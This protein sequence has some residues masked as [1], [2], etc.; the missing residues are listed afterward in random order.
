MS[1]GNNPYS[2]R[3]NTP[4]NNETLRKFSLDVSAALSR[5]SAASNESGVIQ[6][7]SLQGKTGSWS[8]ALYDDVT[9]AIAFLPGVRFIPV[10]GD[11]VNIGFELD[12]SP[13]VG[14]EGVSGTSQGYMAN[15]GI[16]GGS[17]LAAGMSAN[18]ENVNIPRL[19]LGF[20]PTRGATM[21]FYGNDGTERNGELRATLGPAGKFIV[22]RNIDAATWKIMGGIGTNGEVVCGYNGGTWPA[23][24]TLHPLTVYDTAASPQVVAKI[25]KTGVIT[26]SKVTVGNG[27]GKV[28]I[29][30]PASGGEIT[31]TLQQKTFVGDVAPSWV[32]CAATA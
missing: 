21:E 10:G 3:L 32:L 2:V 20:K 26:G 11:D 17:K 9:G 24:D 1:N 8:I 27:S 31:L 22:Y 16:K 7:E 5:L 30:A 14:S 23:A 6:G 25:S 12:V 19:D 13:R 15:F 4:I 28:S 29:Q 18:N